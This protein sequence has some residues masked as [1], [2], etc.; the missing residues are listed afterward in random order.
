MTC[1]TDNLFVEIFE[2]TH[3][4]H[5]FF[6]SIFGFLNRC[7]NFYDEDINVCEQLVVEYLRLWNPSH[8]NECNETTSN[9][10]CA[11][12]IANLDINNDSKTYIEEVMCAST[13]ETNYLDNKTFYNDSNTKLNPSEIVFNNEIEISSSYDLE[14]DNG[15]IMADAK[16]KY[17][18]SSESYNGAVTERYSWSQSIN[19]VDIYIN[20]PEHI[21][22]CAQLN[23]IITPL[24]LKVEFKSDTI[25]Y[26][27]EDF[28]WKCK[29][30]ESVWWLSNGRLLIH[31]QKKEDRW[32]QKLLESDTP[33]DISKMHC[34][35]PL[36]ELPEN[37]QNLVQ[38][39]FWNEKQK[40]MGKPTTDDIR[41]RELLR[42]SWNADGSPFKGTDFDPSLVNFH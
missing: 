31:L 16:F 11:N 36:D 34:S 6:D 15:I 25:P 2:K 13:S 8:V 42:K 9:N 19:E 1:T 14:T 40:I 32:W 38:E 29:P 41:K 4:I 28:S 39:I 24:H 22:S 3:N 12:Q 30:S 35:R 5:S 33:L 27:D 37:A 26:I 18:T 23:V 17:N 7:T 10:V 20:L 21:T